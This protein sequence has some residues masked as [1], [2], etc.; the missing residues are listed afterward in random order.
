MNCS[1]SVLRLLCSKCSTAD[2]LLIHLLLI[3]LLRILILALR[4][5]LILR[6]LRILRIL[7]SI[8]LKRVIIVCHISNH[9]FLIICLYSI[10][11]E[12]N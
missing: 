1:G 12:L 3:S 5:R 10:L 4:I 8:G 2:L 7:G 11:S 9:P 6:V